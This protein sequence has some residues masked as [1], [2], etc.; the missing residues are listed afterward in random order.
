MTPAEL[1]GALEARIRSILDGGDPVLR[2]RGGA[3]H[4]G[5]CIVD[6]GLSPSRMETVPGLPAWTTTFFFYEEAIMATHLPR[7]VSPAG[8]TGAAAAEVP[9]Q[10]L[11]ASSTSWRSR[12]SLL[13]LGLD[14]RSIRALRVVR[15]LR[16]LKL[17]RY[18]HRLRAARR[19]AAS[20]V[21]DELPRL[22][23]GGGAS[24]SICAP[25]RS[26]CSRTRR[27]RRP[28]PPIPHAMWWAVVTFTTVGYGDVYPITTG[29][30]IFTGRHPDPG[31]GRG[32]GADWASIC[33]RPHPARRR[34]RASPERD[35]EKPRQASATPRPE[36]ATGASAATAACRQPPLHR[37]STTTLLTVQ[38]LKLSC[39]RRA[40]APAVAMYSGQN[41][42]LR[43]P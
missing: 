37:L 34:A 29:G 25:P 20:A 13:L 28:S 3:L 38:D 22:R 43:A 7:R 32:R 11:S 27:S 23:H 16:L 14:I 18:V 35:G 2:P 31:A 42:K 5:C 30:R 4:P 17:M 39:R 41:G 40:P 15:V 12:P 8:P 6:V 36:K 10:L 9:V 21:A 33:H 24:C 19:G 26:T 1:P